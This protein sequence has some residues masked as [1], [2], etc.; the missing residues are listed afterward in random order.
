MLAFS[1]AI[2]GD[3]E[4]GVASGDASLATRDGTVVSPVASVATGVPRLGVR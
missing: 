3:S 4:T 1:D 2:A